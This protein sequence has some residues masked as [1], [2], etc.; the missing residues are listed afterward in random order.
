MS[1]ILTVENLVS[2]LSLTAL[3]II[4]GIDNIV[5]LAIL[6]QKLPP[7]QGSKA[8]RLGLALALGTRVLLLLTLTW[9][10]HLTAPLFTIVGKTFSGRDLVLALGGLFLIGKS[11]HEIHDKTEDHAQ[12]SSGNASATLAG[13]VFQIALLDLVFSLDSVITAVGMAPQLWIMIGAVILAMAVMMLT[14]DQTAGFISRHPSMKILGLSFLLLIGVLL[15][16]ESLGH[17]VPRGYVYFAM[18]FS[19][20]VELLNIR[21]RRRNPVPAKIAD[22]RASSS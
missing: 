7:Q 15:V 21:A 17:H 12:P 13:V 22:E 10:S 4:L 20:A 16:A 2:L 3:E 19:L 8:R 9:L 11:V 6:S 14:A 18:G 1:G 5:F